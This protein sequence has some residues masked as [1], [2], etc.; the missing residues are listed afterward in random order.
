MK[1]ENKA[2]KFIGRFF[3]SILCPILVF[4]IIGSA[5][6]TS[7]R[8]MLTVNSVTDILKT[9]P[10][11]EIIEPES[12]EKVLSDIADKSGKNI[13]VTGDSIGNMVNDVLD[14]KPVKEI[15]GIYAED[16]AKIIA[17]NFE[18]ANISSDKIKDI[19][20]EHS[21]EVVEILT[22]N[23][24]ELDKKEAENA[25]DTIIDEHLGELIEEL[26]ELEELNKDLEEIEE[27]KVLGIF[28]TDVIL[29]I[30]WGVVALVA[31]LIFVSRIYHFKGLKWIGIAATVA[32]VILLL[33]ATALNF[34]FIFEIAELELI[35][36]IVAGFASKVYTIGYI[37]FGIGMLFIACGI[38]LHFIY[39]NK[40][41]CEQERLAQG[42]AEAAQ[43]DLA[44]TE[45]VQ[46]V[47]TPKEQ[48]QTEQPK[49]V[50]TVEEQHTTEE[51]QN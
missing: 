7:A 47:V 21:D 22:D 35:V 41:K 37:V 31:L 14:S 27:V 18:S 40:S 13:E 20:S 44:K 36:P 8:S 6:F 38:A 50:E 4:M 24:P 34:E 19:F 23:Y 9:I 15:V 39:K 45:Q 3:A 46:T 49:T 26:P 25:V 2:L 17:G 29:Y 10:Y 16:V 48:V 32:S 33:V 51:T 11:E 1:K 30:I 28:F 43:E 12:F 5:I 42:Q